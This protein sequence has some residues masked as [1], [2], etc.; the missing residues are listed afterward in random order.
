MLYKVVSEITVPGVVKLC[1][2]SDVA[3]HEWH[4]DYIFNPMSLGMIKTKILRKEYR[5]LDSFLADLKW[6]QHNSHVF[7]SAKLY[8][9]ADEFVKKAEETCREI[10]KRPDN[11]LLPRSQFDCSES[12]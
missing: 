11:F 5:S 12:D 10:E 6:I 4:A 2:W 8:D 7:E 3:K 9:I 1:N